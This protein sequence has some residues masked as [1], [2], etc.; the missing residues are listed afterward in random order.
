[1]S[2]VNGRSAPQN[3]DVLVL[4]G[5]A[6]GLACALYLLRQGRSVTVL[7]QGT[8]AGACSH[9]NCGTITPSH[10][11]PLAMPGMISQALR[12]LFKSDAPFHVAPRVDPRLWGWLLQFARRCTWRDF[13]YTTAAKA[14]LLKLAREALEELVHAE[15]FDCEFEASGTLNVYRDAAA[16]EKSRWLPQ[17]LR[18]VGLTVE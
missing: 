8:A 11:H 9:G 18:E 6:I 3:S 15:N 17:A 4:G 13:R 1:M 16:L 5:G 12:W 2:N 10:S 14:P 7:E